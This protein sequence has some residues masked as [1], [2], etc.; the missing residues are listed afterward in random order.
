MVHEAVLSTFDDDP[1]V[2]NVPALEL[3][4]HAVAVLD[5]D[6]RVVIGHDGEDGARDV[7]EPVDGVLRLLAREM[8][9]D[10]PAVDVDAGPKLRRIG[11]QEQ[12]DAPA[13][14]EADD[15]DGVRRERGMLAQRRHPGLHVP[16]RLRVVQHPVAPRLLLPVAQLLHRGEAGEEVDGE[17]GVAHLGEAPGHV[18]GVVGEAEDLVEDEDTGVRP[19]AV[20]H[21]EEGLDAARARRNGE[22]GGGVLHQRLGGGSPPARILPQRAG[23]R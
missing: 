6:Q 13:H 20:G 11:G 14:R 5:R 8:V 9:V 10:R 23:R 22:F 17:A 7:L 19:G 15:A 4:A 16:H 1:F 12:R 3:P 21:G 2:W 18:A